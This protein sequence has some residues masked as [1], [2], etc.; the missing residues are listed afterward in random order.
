MTEL[1][2]L[3]F[4]FINNAVLFEKGTEDYVQIKDDKNDLSTDRTSAI[5]DSLIKL[6]NKVKENPDNKKTG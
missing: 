4:G 3:T 5:E 2:I 1:L 6:E